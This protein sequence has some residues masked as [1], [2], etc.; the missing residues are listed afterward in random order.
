M[1]DRDKVLVPPNWDSWGKIRVLREGFDVEGV[2][3]GWSLDIQEPSLSSSNSS[4]NEASTS[5]NGSATASALAVYEETIVSPTTNPLQVSSLAS[6]SPILDVTSQDS[7]LFLASQLESLERLRTATETKSSGGQREGFNRV[8]NIG[9]DLVSV[10]D[11]NGLDD[12]RVNEHIGPVQ[13]NMGGIQVDADD[14]LRRLK[15]CLHIVVLWHELKTD[16]SR[17]GS[18]MQPLIQRHQ[19]W[20]VLVVGNRR[21]SS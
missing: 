2:N 13:F 11:G 14:M 15:V 7:Q 5:E 16:K 12:G 6:S 3:R 21:M 1:I 20:A 10:E 18:Q 4:V 17:T 9:S 8:T 19:A